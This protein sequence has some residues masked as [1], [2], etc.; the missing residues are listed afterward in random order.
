MIQ[1]RVFLKS[2]DGQ[3]KKIYSIRS[4]LKTQTIQTQAWSALLCK[5]LE[6][7][8]DSEVHYHFPSNGKDFHLTIRYQDLG[9]F[10]DPEI[11]KVNNYLH[12]YPTQDQ[13]KH[14]Q[15][16]YRI[17]QKP[18]INTRF[19]PF[20][21]EV[22]TKYLLGYPPDSFA[23]YRE[24]KSK[25]PIYYFPTISIPIY[26]FPVQKGDRTKSPPTENDIVIDESDEPD[27]RINV[28]GFVC[29]PGYCYY[30]EEA[31]YKSRV[32]GGAAIPDF[33]ISVIFS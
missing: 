8:L 1:C 12:F 31:N 33:G 13:Y 6:I 5:E 28:C 32:V 29:S 18:S 24:K 2:F 4:I 7:P 25:H 21:K 26:P 10:T 11:I 16:I 22:K 14:K 3:L 23:E 27:V 19:I 15:E 9:P 17:S 20:T 30:K